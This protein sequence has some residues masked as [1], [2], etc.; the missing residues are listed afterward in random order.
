MLAEV[1]AQI[2][3]P[4]HGRGRPRTRPEAVIAD[5]AYATGVI[6]TELRRRGIK[7]VIPDKRDQA[8]ARKRRGSKGGRPPG[9]RRRRLQG[10]QRRRA[11]LRPRQAV[12]RHRDTLRQARDHLPC[13]R[14]P[15]RDPHLATPIGRH[16]RVSLDWNSHLL[17]ARRVDAPC[18]APWHGATRHR[19]Q[20]RP[21]DV[22]RLPGRSGLGGCDVA[23]FSSRASADPIRVDWDKT[24]RRSGQGGPEAGR[25]GSARTRRGLS[26]GWRR[27]LH[28]RE[29]STSTCGPTRSADLHPHLG[30]AV[31][32]WTRQLSDTT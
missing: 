26:D 23:A 7:A 25:R 27:N 19:P 10:P 28:R 14:H 20:H 2:H 30:R 17:K 24:R 3:V 32:A 4:R 13:R 22:S 5:R 29:T 21:C 1:L 18:V 6:R 31:I 16:A 15:L 8:A 12:A 9:A 11:V